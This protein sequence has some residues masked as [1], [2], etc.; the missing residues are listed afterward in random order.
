MA[1]YN[2]NL[3]LMATAE[4]D[5]RKIDKQHLSRIDAAI[6]SLADD[7]YPSS[8]RKLQTKRGFLRIRVGNYRIIYT[9]DEALKQVLI[10]YIRI[11]DTRTY[12]KL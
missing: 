3:F 6:L 5:L 11:R 8:S 1:S 10:Y 9:V 2:Y 4:R 12:K 7:P